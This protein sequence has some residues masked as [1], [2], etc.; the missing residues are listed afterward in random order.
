MLPKRSWTEVCLRALVA[1]AMISSLTAHAASRQVAVV[2]PVDAIDC[3]TNSITVLG[4]RFAAEAVAATVICKSFAVSSYVSAVGNVESTGTIRL[5][6]LSLVADGVYVPG[7]TL[8][9]VR[10]E[11]S[12]ADPI[13]GEISLSG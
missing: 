5:G 10:A 11:V 9:Y 3:Q 7:A 13:T 4:V 8:V 2:G 12:K 1:F 6:K